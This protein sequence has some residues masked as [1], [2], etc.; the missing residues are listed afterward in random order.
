MATV[1][2]APTKLLIAPTNAYAFIMNA[3][4]NGASILPP[5]GTGSS[6]SYDPKTHDL[7]RVTSAGTPPSANMFFSYSA[8]VDGKACYT[9]DGTNNFIYLAL[10]T[11]TVASIGDADRLLLISTSPAR[12]IEIWHNFVKQSDTGVIA[13]AGDELCISRNDSNVLYLRNGEVFYTAATV[14]GSYFFRWASYGAGTVQSDI[15]IS[16]D[17]PNYDQVSPSF[18]LGKGSIF[19]SNTRF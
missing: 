8:G 9:Y 10:E 19:G 17:L 2:V 16:G 12:E 4:L 14:T 1:S 18:Y 13:V 3:I 11:G 6:Y 5:Y 15:Y 7:T